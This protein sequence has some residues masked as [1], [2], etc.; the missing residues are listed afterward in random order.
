M[1]EFKENAIWIDAVLCSGS[2]TLN[3]LEALSRVERFALR[4]KIEPNGD[5]L[6]HPI[7][8]LVVVHFSRGSGILKKTRLPAKDQRMIIAQSCARCYG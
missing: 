6:A 2:M 8:S 7:G 3:A 1:G 4:M 5:F